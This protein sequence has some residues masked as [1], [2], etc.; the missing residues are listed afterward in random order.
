DRLSADDM[1]QFALAITCGLALAVAAALALTVIMQRQWI[2]I[3]Q[4]DRQ[5]TEAR[6][7]EQQQRRPAEGRRFG[8]ERHQ[9]STFIC[10]GTM[11]F[12]NPIVGTAVKLQQRPSA[13]SGLAIDMDGGKVTWGAYTLPITENKGN[14]IVFKGN[15][16]ERTDSDPPIVLHYSTSGTMD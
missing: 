12:V 7:E 9:P 8:V 3:E 5:Q 13:E 4:Q 15:T 1:K 16:E 11:S 10:Q 14:I 6:L 2:V